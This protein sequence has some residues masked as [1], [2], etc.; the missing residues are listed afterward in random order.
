MKKNS[1]SLTSFSS[2][3]QKIL[4]H[5][6]IIAFVLAMGTLIYCV[7]SIQLI[8]DLPQDQA[9][10]DDRLKNN[11]ISSFDQKTINQ[12]KQLRTTKEKIT[13]HPD[14][15]FNPFME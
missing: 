15:Y 2:L 6:S 4:S 5:S 13:I 11:S 8:F 10:Y 9:Y 14:S 1:L 12:V 3:G 7:F